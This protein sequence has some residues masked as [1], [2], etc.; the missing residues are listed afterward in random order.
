VAD[1]A[2]GELTSFNFV[3]GYETLA[4]G[5]LISGRLIAHIEYLVARPDKLGRIPVTFKAPFHVQGID[6][7]CQ[8]HLVYLPVTGLTANALTDVNAMVK[9]HEVW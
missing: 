5:F 9:I 7:P 1:R 8:R 4:K 6:F 2:I 3:F